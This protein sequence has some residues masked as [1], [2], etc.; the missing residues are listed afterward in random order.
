MYN[1]NKSNYRITPPPVFPINRQKSATSDINPKNQKR[2]EKVHQLFYLVF[3]DF[4]YAN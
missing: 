4:L 3:L 1:K 2:H